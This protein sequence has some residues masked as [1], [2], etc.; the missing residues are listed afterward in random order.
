MRS[1]RRLRFALPF[2]V[3]AGLVTI[4]A[5]AHVVQQPDPTDASFLSPTSD[6]GDGAR[7]LADRLTGGGVQVDVRTTSTDA[8]ASAASGGP[9]TVLVTTPELVN[10]VYLGRLAALPPQ[11]RVILVAP[12]AQQ[13]G[14]LGLDVAV[15]GPRW[16]AAA[17]RPGCAAGFAGT[18]GRAAALR[19][20]YDPRG[21]GAVRCYRDGLVELRTARAAITLIG[22]ADPFRNDR[23]GEHGNQALAAGLLARD[24]RVIWLD[25]H[26]R[27]PDPVTDTFPQQEPD[28]GTDPEGEPGYGTGDEP[29]GSPQGDPAGDPQNGDQNPRPGR[30]QD[31]QAQGGGNPVTDSPLARA[32]PPVVWATLALL[33]LAALALAAASARRLGAPVAEPLPVRVRAAETV[34]GLGGLYRRAGARGNSLATL[35]AAA[36]RRLTEHFGLPPDAGMDEVA[37]RVAA[38]TGHPVNEV[39]HMLGGGVEDS[40][41]E[42]AR[43]ATTVQNLVRYVTG[44]QNW[45]QGTDEG[46]VT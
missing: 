23:A 21:Y 26:E 29:G 2:A 5:I 37:E 43:A 45:R 31:G 22:A 34:R 4:T 17:P 14:L 6:D 35:Q 44:R 10:P 33:A 1:R 28:P 36:S 42:L 24:P 11:V 16:M 39:R 46:N 7:L 3:V 30:G 19:R 13:V 38:V 8:L 27:E 20:S 15:G 9:A 12:D 40:D 25:L 41:E 32:F 18:A